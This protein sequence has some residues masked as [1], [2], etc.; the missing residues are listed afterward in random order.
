M[1][2]AM[3][4]T[5]RMFLLQVGLGDTLQTSPL[6]AL[7][8][9]F[10]AGVLTSLTPCIYPMIPIT[11]GV[12]TGT[13]G[14]EASRGRVVGLTLTYVSGLAL[15]YA[16]AG[17][18]AGLSGTLFGT[19]ASSWWAQGLI[20]LLLA[21]FG[22]AMLDVIPVPAPRR[23]TTWAGSLG[24][25]SY[26]AV[27]LLGA[28]SGLVAAPC[29]APA[30][31]AVLTWVGAGGPLFRLCPVPAAG[32]SL[33]AVAQEGGGRASAGHG[34][35]VRLARL[36]G[37]CLMA[38]SRIAGS[39]FMK[40]D[41]ISGLA[42]VALFLVAALLLLSG[43]LDAQTTRIGI[44]IGAT[45]A[46]LSL[47][48]LD[49]PGGTVDLSES[50]GARPVLLEFWATWCENCEALHPQMLKAHEEFGDVVDFFAVAV[51]VNQSPR[52]I[53]R[54]L[55]EM[56]LPFPV[57]WDEKGAAVRAFQAPNTSYIV[58]L[59]ANGRVTYTGTGSDQDIEAAVRT[60]LRT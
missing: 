18:L 43:P 3:G 27:F 5:I 31:A 46:G 25:G 39:V 19:L 48:R 44:E 22:L 28:T 20:A 21:L 15:L 56:P 35:L 52:R 29:G 7:P 8:L 16:L 37:T 51:G 14:E 9:L 50:I 17:L 41:R 53:R 60:A 32:R 58:V 4:E 33:D 54:H 34:S 13:A 45:P 2:F 40:H 55:E 49:G 10:G 59:D 11:A 12:I 6:L 26:P 24:A 57:L 1:R 23:L 38:F 42:S 36:A 47:D 30:F